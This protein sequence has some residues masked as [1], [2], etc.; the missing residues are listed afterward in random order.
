MKD[1]K[2]R[3]KKISRRGEKIDHMREVIKHTGEGWLETFKKEKK[4]WNGM[5]NIK[6]G[7]LHIFIQAS[8]SE[9]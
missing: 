2:D 4:C 5:Q 7:V 3:K 1:K 6:T 9:A 8:G